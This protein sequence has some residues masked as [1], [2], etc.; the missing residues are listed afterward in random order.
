[1]IFI[2]LVAASGRNLFGIPSLQMHIKYA[3][4]SNKNAT[5]YINLSNLTNSRAVERILVF[6]QFWQRE[7]KERKEER[8]KSLCSPQMETYTLNCVLFAYVTKDVS[9]SKMVS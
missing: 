2:L 4:N 5:K 3:Y 6:S 8:D 1:M 9:L 7:R